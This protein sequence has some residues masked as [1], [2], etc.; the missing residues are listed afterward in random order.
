LKQAKEWRLDLGIY[1]KNDR[2]IASD[3]IETLYDKLI[4][5]AENRGWCIGGRIE[6]SDELCRCVNVKSV[7]LLARYSISPL[8]CRDCFG[9]VAFEQIVIDEKVKEELKS[10]QRLYESFYMLWLDSDGYE[11]MGLHE[12]TNP[13]SIL[14][15][16]GFEL[17]KKLQKFL[18][19]W[20]W[21]F[22]QSIRENFEVSQK[23]PLCGGFLEA[24]NHGKCCIKC[25]LIIQ[26]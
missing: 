24:C 11:S 19:V 25:K 18:D 23:C 14:N 6:A 16:R 9:T 12:L 13:K 4:A 15:Q 1:A 5:W 10:W 26:V 21:W 22:T 8:V 2:F 3:E 20:Y 7:I 17:Q